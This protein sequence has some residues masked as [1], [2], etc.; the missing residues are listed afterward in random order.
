MHS[1]LHNLVD[2]IIVKKINRNI[3]IQHIPT[4]EDEEK[5][6]LDLKK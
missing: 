6:E 2:E 5:K 3:E 4:D 1:E